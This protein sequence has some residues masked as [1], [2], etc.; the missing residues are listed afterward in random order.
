MV[1]AIKYIKCDLPHGFGM[2]FYNFEDKKN[3]D[4]S[5]QQEITTNTWVP[6]GG[7]K[8]HIRIQIKNVNNNYH[9]DSEFFLY[10][11]YFKLVMSYSGGMN[12]LLTVSGDRDIGITVT[13]T[14]VQAY[15]NVI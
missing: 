9:V 15:F 5:E 8:E 13:A 14:G 6:Y 11:D 2:N 4:L 12:T 3:I 1:M 10:D 7:S